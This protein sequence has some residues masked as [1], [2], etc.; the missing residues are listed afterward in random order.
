MINRIVHTIYNPHQ[1]DKQVLV[2]NFIVRTE[3]FNRI[4]KE[5]KESTMERP[6]N[7]MIL[8]GQ[9]GM[10]KTTFLLRL[11]YEIEDDKDLKRWLIPIIFKEK[12][13]SINSLASLWIRV[14]GYLTD[15]DPSFNKLLEEVIVEEDSKFEEK[16]FPYEKFI[17]NKLVNTLNEKEK[18]LILFIDNFHSII[19]TLNKNEQQRL[20]EIL[21]TCADIRLI[22]A[23][24]RMTEALN[25]YSSPLY[26]NLNVRSLDELNKEDSQK[27]FEGLAKQYDDIASRERIEKIIKEKSTTIEAFRRLTGGLVRTM[28]FLFD[29]FVTENIGTTINSL[30][31]LTDDITPYYDERLAQLG[32][33]TQSQKIV[34][35]IALNYDGISVKELR[36][37]TR[38]PSKTISATLSKLVE[39]ELIKKIPSNTKNH[40]Y[41]IKER[42][43]NIWYI[44]RY[45]SKTDS[46]KIIFLTRFLEEWLPSKEYRGKLEKLLENYKNEGYDPS[47]IDVL[48]AFQES[49][50][51]K[52]GGYIEKNIDQ[53][54]HEGEKLKNYA[55][56]SQE[57]ILKYKRSLTNPN[58][59][60]FK[61]KFIALLYLSNISLA[62]K[63]KIIKVFPKISYATYQQILTSLEEER[64]Y[65]KN[66]P[67]DY[68]DFIFNRQKPIITHKD[69]LE[70][71]LINPDFEYN[72]KEFK[73]LL[74]LS[75]M[76]ID[77][78]K[79]IV[80]KFST[81]TAT[82]FQNILKALK[83]EAVF[84]EKKAAMQMQNDDTS[85][86]DKH[87]ALAKLFN[88]YF[89]LPQQSLDFYKKSAEQGNF[90][91]YELGKLYLEN[92][93]INQAERFFTIALEDDNQ[94]QAAHDLGNIYLE[95]DDKLEDA[96]ARFKESY[97]KTTNKNSLF[98]AAWVA[99]ELKKFEEAK[100]DYLD[101][102]EQSK[103][104][105]IA[106]NNLANV[107]ES[108]GDF[109]KA[110][111]Y[112][113]KAI[114]EK[115]QK[116]AKR[117]LANLYI[118]KLD[119][120]EKGEELLKELI[121]EEEDAKAMND[122]AWNYYLQKINKEDALKYARSAFQKEKDSV[123][124]AHTYATILLW[125]EKI[126]ESLKPCKVFLSSPRSFEEFFKDIAD[127]LILLIAK[128]GYK[129][130]YE[131]FTS[132]EYKKYR[133]KDRYKPI[134]YALMNEEY[135]KKKYPNEYLKMGSDL[136]KT[137]E[138]EVREEI[139]NKREDY[140]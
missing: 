67:T 105:R 92:K 120:F 57:D 121:K 80:K 101:Y 5:I 106:Y 87:I 108:L 96:R 111:S 117:N 115:E 107:Y 35:Y 32:E 3:K 66:E 9:R 72:A 11:N 129:I 69:I 76:N 118:K 104:K 33:H 112:Y 128:K 39:S 24:T 81:L 36:K 60:F 19:E 109:K 10:G 46:Q 135:M 77:T 49:K 26:D 110:R 99:H 37:K 134:Y 7:H 114:A 89:N 73:D 38:I 20:R 116:F 12:E 94:F 21:T 74:Y 43:F 23:A 138:E 52:L 25:S 29:I 61:E 42:F 100:L 137:V 34:H 126:K 1:L 113:E 93:D 40:L 98:K 18:K 70:Y 28:V 75:S 90:S 85:I 48:Q 4:F 13:Y 17:F 45:G 127:Y 47:T 6:E 88:E 84:L 30:T 22:A 95:E 123:N 131:L 82:S 139:E 140:K 44:M 130:A 55:L 103:E 119:E 71:N 83:K 124:F 86:K 54:L 68:L 15:K 91:N 64:K 102:I 125:N 41:I 133:L 50:V 27:L 78:K 8:L 62:S 16:E 132:S 63:K 53:I 51:I 59:S 56:D 58:F 2:E 14:I 122:L 79:K 136:K 65:L 97:D 31:Q